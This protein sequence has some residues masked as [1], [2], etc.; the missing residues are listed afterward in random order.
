MEDK[1]QGE[2]EGTEGLQATNR[3]VTEMANQM[4]WKE[5][6]ERKNNIVIKGWN[7]GRERQSLIRKIEDFLKDRIEVE[8]KIVQARTI[9]KNRIVQAKVENWKDK[10]KIMQNKSKN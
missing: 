5:R 2:T 6:E 3:Q 9:G 8:A 4:E 10:I 7:V 1:K